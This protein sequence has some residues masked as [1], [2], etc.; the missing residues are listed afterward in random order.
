MVS[1]L[2]Q[3]LE[4]APL[5][6]GTLY[7]AFP[8]AVPGDRVLRLMDDGTFR[9]EQVGAG[10]ALTR[11]ALP[12]AEIVGLITTATT[13]LA[14]QSE[15]DALA[16]T[17][18]SEAQQEI[19]ARYSVNAEGVPTFDGLPIG[20]TPPATGTISAVVDLAAL[21][22]FATQTVAQSPG[23]A[24]LLAP[25]AF[26]ASNGFTLDA[27]TASSITVVS[28]VANV[29]TPLVEGQAFT[30]RVTA[31]A[32]P[33][34]AGDPITRT[35]DVAAAADYFARI[36]ALADETAEIEFNPALPDGASA[37][38]NVTV[39]GETYPIA[40]A[41]GDDAETEIAADLEGGTAL[42]GTLTPVPGFFSY[43]AADAPVTLGPLQL[44]RNGTPVALTGGSYTKVGG[45]AGATFQARQ[46]LTL[47][48]GQTITALSDPITLQA[49]PQV[50]VN[51]A[52]PTQS[53]ASGPVGTVLTLTNGTWSNS[54]T[55]YAY[56]WR[57]GGQ[58]IAGA[59]GQS[60]TTVAD[61]GG[62][63]IVGEVRASNASGQ[64]TG[65]VAAT[66][67]T[68][69]AAPPVTAPNLTRFLAGPGNA[70]NWALV[71]ATQDGNGEIVLPGGV[72]SD[73]IVDFDEAAAPGNYYLFSA[74][75]SFD[76]TVGSLTY[77]DRFANISNPTY[78]AFFYTQSGR[79]TYKSLLKMGTKSGGGAP[80]VRIRTASNGPAGRIHDARTTPYTLP[81]PVPLLMDVNS[82]VAGTTLADGAARNGSN[83]IVMTRGATGNPLV[84]IQ[85]GALASP[86]AVNDQIRIRFRA[87]SASAP[88]F[89][90]RRGNSGMDSV[91]SEIK[92]VSG[93]PGFW[94]CEILFPVT[95]AFPTTFGVRLATPSAV[96]SVVTLRDFKAERLA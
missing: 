78:S 43:S 29:S 86:L 26:V 65:Y 36:V 12:E 71:N 2:H 63:T 30:L 72:A 48:G 14:P 79:Q 37:T 52:A 92:A 49:A 76:A 3:L 67:G 11:I 75:V 17:I 62:Q 81:N 24:A 83:D 82:N 70:P 4:G 93:Q 18:P 94:D 35:F 57:R 32:Q 47:A 9:M 61:D 73:V 68:S 1:R 85:V 34:G 53:P 44:L 21:K 39:D 16:A 89:S 55:A 74:D 91:Q 77:G 19:W 69:V 5:P 33:T 90:I 41:K 84:T 15:L 23:Y 27:L 58:I 45:D 54:P 51:T 64:A 8:A 31:T 40:V 80:G 7:D 20:T 42:T 10:L 38:L 56:Q 46:V 87:E 59:T 28:G 13:G 50:P 66:T 22:F 25:G 6:D 96:G 95:P 60:Y 88:T